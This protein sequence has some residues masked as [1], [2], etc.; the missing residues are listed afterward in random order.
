MGFL[1]LAVSILTEVTGSTMLKL[2][3][4]FRKRLPVIGMI[5]S[6]LVSFYFLSLT[7]LHIPLSLAY[8]IWSGV[9]TALTALAGV[10]FFREQLTR[11][12]VIGIAM[13]LV[14]VV[15]LIL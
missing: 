11:S 4:G 12:T 9:G 10:W 8:A 13:L 3:D 14:G 5:A 1:L 6:F 7:L 15:L 2:S